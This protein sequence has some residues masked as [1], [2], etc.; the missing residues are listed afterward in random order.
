[1]TVLVSVTGE[2]ARLRQTTLVEPTSDIDALDG[3]VTRLFSL[4]A[5]GIARATTSFLAS[6][7]QAA[8]LLVAE[9]EEVD[10]VFHAVENL[11]RARWCPARLRRSPGW[12]AC[13]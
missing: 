3:H 6:A 12:R 7:R 10:A 5:E 11:I 9:E 4:V 1:M 2:Q 8:A 13:W